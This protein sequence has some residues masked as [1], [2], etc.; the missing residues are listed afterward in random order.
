[1]KRGKNSYA[2]ARR[3]GLSYWRGSRRR[4]SGLSWVV[5]FFLVCLVICVVGYVFVTF[6]VNK[7]NISKLGYPFSYSDYIKKYADANGLDPLF[8]A[9]VIREESR[10]QPNAVSAKGACGL[11]QL[12]PAT[13]EEVARKMGETSTKTSLMQPENN[14]RYGTAYLASLM[15]KYDGDLVLSLAAYNAGSGR[16]DSWVARKKGAF[17]VGD[18]PFQETRDYVRK[19]LESYKR[20][21]EL[22]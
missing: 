6:N 2:I 9:A 18:I 22:Y 21:Q 13:A 12:M 14:I 3:G 4:K 1:M 19:V 20:Y 7:L 5:K 8:V 11:M 17:T 15:K 16:V 10:F